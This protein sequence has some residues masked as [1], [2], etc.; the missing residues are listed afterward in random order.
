MVEAKHEADSKPAPFKN[1][2]RKVR[3]PKSSQHLKPAPPASIFYLDIRLFS[4]VRTLHLRFEFPFR[5][6]PIIQVMAQLP[7]TFNIDFVCSN[8]DFL[9]A[10]RIRF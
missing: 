1:Q 9:E 7:A 5:L 8:S 6:K 2:T 4:R 3:H 10:R